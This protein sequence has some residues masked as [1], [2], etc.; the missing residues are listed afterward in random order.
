MTDDIFVVQILTS[1]PNGYPYDDIAEIAVCSVNLTDEKV[2]L[3]YEQVVSI[4]P[5]NLG[6]S[7]LEYLFK[8]FGIS[9]EELAS[10]EPASAVSKEVLDIIKGH[11]VAC[12]DAR[13]FSRYMTCSPW[14][15][16]FRTTV[17]SSVSTK[18]PISLRCKDPADEPDIIRK[19]Y[20]R[21]FR[22]DPARVG[23]GRQA[24]HLAMMTSYVAIDMR[25]RGKF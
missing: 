12:F 22:N 20:R 21:T 13:Q 15:L 1:G 17:M 2:E 23:R 11:T 14:D 4:E 16:T 8:R 19:A 10:G 25:K 7:K 9:A 18:M 24:G 5:K 6:R 3:L